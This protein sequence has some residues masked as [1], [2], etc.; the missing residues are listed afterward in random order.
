MVTTDAFIKI[1]A[2]PSATTGDVFVKANSPEL[3]MVKAGDKV[4]AIQSASGGTLYVTEGSP[5]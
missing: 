2:V 3:F 4:S 1:A 5:S